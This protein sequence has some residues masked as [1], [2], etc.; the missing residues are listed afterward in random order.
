VIDGFSEFEPI[1]RGDFSVVY[2]AREA[3]VDRLVA[4]K[5]LHGVSTDDAMARDRF[6]REVRAMGRL[7]GIPN[8]VD[9]YRPVFTEHGEPCIVM[10]YLAGGN[11][12]ELLD[13]QG[14]LWAS[15][16]RDL[17]VTIATALAT[18]HSR[19]IHHRD[20]KPENILLDTD[21]TP[22]L[23]DF[24]IAVMAD[25]RAGSATA[26]TL[27]PPHAP[28]ER[29]AP[30]PNA[31]N[32]DAAGDV[33]SLGSTLYTL[34]AGQPPFGN[35]HDI[36]THKFNLAV[37]N[38]PPPPLPRADVPTEL[39]TLI[40][41]CLAKDPNQRPT[42]TQLAHTLTTLHITPTPPDPTAGST[43]NREHEATSG[44]RETPSA[45]ADIGV[46]VFRQRA[47]PEI[48][49]ADQPTET[50]GPSKKW[51][52]LAAGTVAL[53]L[54]AFVTS[55]ALG[56]QSE[57]E[58]TT[59]S[60]FDTTSTPPRT[61]EP[62]LIEPPTPLS[63]STG[64]SV[65]WSDPNEPPAP[66]RWYAVAVDGGRISLPS[67]SEDLT[68]DEFV[69]ADLDFESGSEPVDI[70]RSQYCVTVFVSESDPEKGQASNTEC[71]GPTG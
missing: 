66:L 42:A 11:L 40:Q 69:V 34:L 45:P 53:F 22:Y 32:N 29:I 3:Y 38:N 58:T 28:P 23:G 27:S 14:P 49:Y 65:R 60:G 52:V 6:L 43:T 61:L 63:G 26:A 35:P 57:E 54:L 18:A 33:Y 59:T 20:I 7:S 2:R 55:Q 12:T 15:D 47:E 71:I 51:A 24:G 39:D 13:T 1:G 10:P 17:G 48:L 70:T 9:V 21:N 44:H 8:V 50:S 19:G 4:I 25:L 36:G 64:F 56:G 5:V 37:L 46:T 68:A 16:V 31:A 41:D 67:E 30:T 62:L